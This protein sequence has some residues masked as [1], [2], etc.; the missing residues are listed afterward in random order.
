MSV[1]KDERKYL[2]KYMNYMFFLSLSIPLISFSP[3][4]YLGHVYIQIIHVVW[5]F[6][7]LNVVWFEKKNENTCIIRE[8]M[9]LYYI[10]KSQTDIANCPQREYQ[11]DTAL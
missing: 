6:I 1:W 10:W 9:V 3:C 8:T 2:S 11:I 5:S 4:K 7:V